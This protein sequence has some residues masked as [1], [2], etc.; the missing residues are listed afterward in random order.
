M[1]QTAAPAQ[2][3]ELDRLF[4][5]AGEP[6]DLQEGDVL[7]RQGAPDSSVYALQDG[8]LAVFASTPFGEVQL[9][10]LH[11][12]AIVGE[13]AA[14]AGI[15]RTASVKALSKARVLRLDGER[16]LEEGR[17]NPEH[18]VRVIRKL[19]S[20]IETVNQAIGLYTNALTA[21][22]QQSLSAD[23]LA[24]LAS[25]PPQMAGFASVFARFASE[26]TAKRKQQEELASAALIQQSFLPRA[27][28]LKT[29]PGS[30]SLYARMRAAKQVG[31]DF[32]D[33][34]DLGNGRLL[35]VI[36]D[37]CGK[38][39]PASLF[40]AVV[41]TTLRSLAMGHDDIGAF[42]AAANSLICANNSSSLFATAVIGVLDTTS[43]RFTYCNWGHCPAFHLRDT[44]DVA[45]LGNTGLPLG[46]FPSKAAS[47][48][49]VT[50]AA[51]DTLLFYSDGITEA[52]NPQ[53]EE[54]GE[55][56][57]RRFVE[58]AYSRS[59]KSLVEV[60]IEQAD[61][62]AAGAEQADDITCMALRVAAP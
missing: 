24:Q 21:L 3:S 15:S 60:V 38:G 22:E 46:L 25:P 45:E 11:P 39:M 54:F 48:A 14:L 10:T 43:R 13:I 28:D 41:I 20:E 30:V 40:M 4:R 36:G 19:G 49:S 57:L 58:S 59:A 56:R 47:V 18:F 12:P 9:A 35:L 6:H 8:T 50:L 61:S 52:V 37:V 2:S 29:L 62:F 27:S 7:I 26:I 1:S 51:G 55:D 53:L 23:V 32:Y 44:G 5:M 42:T 33:Y 31:G 16:L 34:R 17:K